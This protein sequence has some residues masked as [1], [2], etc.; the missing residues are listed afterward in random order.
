MLAAVVT[1][2]AATLIAVALVYRWAMHEGLSEGEVRA[3]GFAAV[4]LGN[5]F[6]ILATRSSE[7][8][9]VSTLLRPNRA[10]WLV[11]AATL[12]ALALVIYVEPLAELLRFKALSATALFAAMAAVPWRC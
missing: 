9:V 1:V 11:I 5:I 8:S 12:A 2:G 10:L 7:R 3:I 4:V 6:L